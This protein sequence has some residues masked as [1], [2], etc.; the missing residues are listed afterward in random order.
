VLAG[1][2]GQVAENNATPPPAVSVAAVPV[3]TVSQ[4]DEASYRRPDLDSFAPCF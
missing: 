2:S 1:C 3:K 4:W